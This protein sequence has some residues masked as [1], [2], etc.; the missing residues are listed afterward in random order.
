[1]GNNI[2]DFIKKVAGGR[3]AGI[4]IAKD[5]EE[6]EIFSRRMRE[7]GLQKAENVFDLLRC[8]KAYFAVSEDSAKDTYDF[9]LQYPTG[10]VEI[11]DKASMHSEVLSPDYERSAIVILIEKNLLA[12]IEAKGF[13]LLS[14]AGPAYQS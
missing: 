14:A 12:K 8:P 1:M 2:E 11:F 6:A 5:A 13:N 4:A 7:Q 9:L 10:Q 3:E